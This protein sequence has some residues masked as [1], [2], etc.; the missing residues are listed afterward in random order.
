MKRSHF[1]D[2]RKVEGRRNVTRILRKNKILPKPRQVSV[3][4]GEIKR[5]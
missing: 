1:I 3:K 2:T 4:F 5:R